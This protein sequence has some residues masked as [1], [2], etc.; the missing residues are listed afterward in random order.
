MCPRGTDWI[1]LEL[2]MPGWTAFCKGWSLCPTINVPNYAMLWSL[3]KEN[4]DTWTRVSQSELITDVQKAS[5]Q[6]IDTI[7]RWFGKTNSAASA[8]DSAAFEYTLRRIVSDCDSISECS[9]DSEHVKKNKREYK[10]AICDQNC[11][12][13][14]TRSCPRKRKQGWQG[15]DAKEFPH[16]ACLPEMQTMS[17]Q[18]KS[19]EETDEMFGM[20]GLLGALGLSAQRDGSEPGEAGAQWPRIAAAFA[21][22]MALCG[23]VGVAVLKVRS[24]AGAH[25]VGEVGPSPSKE[26]ADAEDATGYQNTAGKSVDV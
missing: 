10:D 25:T 12:D 7:Y 3:R 14:A 4:A 16:E 22:G 11:N 2:E 23:L 20:T 21:S 19:K 6:L 18:V 17:Y 9:S 8:D 13:A 24:H 26:W 5:K 1:D 15:R